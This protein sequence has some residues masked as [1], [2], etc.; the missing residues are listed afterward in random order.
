MASGFV[1]QVFML[2][3]ALETAREKADPEA[4]ARD[5]V[6]H[7]HERVDASEE[8]LGAAAQRYPAMRSR[9]PRLMHSAAIL[10]NCFGHGEQ[11]RAQDRVR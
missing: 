7:L 8:R 2:Q 10:F 3:L 4:W 11:R 1:L 9:E 6:L 5:F